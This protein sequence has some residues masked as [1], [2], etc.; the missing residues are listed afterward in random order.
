LAAPSSERWAAIVPLLDAAL[1]LEP[2]ERPAFLTERC[3]HEPGLR[4]EVERLLAAVDSLGTFLEDSASV[5]ASPLV[6]RI[7]RQERFGPGDRLGAYRIEREIGR[8]GMA[9]VYLAR[10]TRHDRPVAL[11]VLDRE[12]SSTLG[13]DRFGR[14]TA[15]AARLNHPHILPLFDSGLLDPGPGEPVLYY[16]MPYVD[17]RSLRERLREEPRLPIGVAV[18][19]A[20]QVAEAL[21]H[22]HERGIVH[23]DI[24]PENV[25]LAGDHAF[26][27]DFGIALAIDAAGTERLTRTGL[28]LGTPAYMSPE[29][30]T[31]GRLDGR[32]DLYSLGCM[33]YEML[34]GRPPFTGATAQA[35]LAQH[36]AGAAPPV[37]TFRTAVPAALER[38]VTRA[39]A[40]APEDRFPTGRALAEALAAA[41]GAAPTRMDAAY[42]F[43]MPALRSI[44]RHRVRAALVAGG[45]A[46][47]VAGFGLAAHS[48]RVTPTLDRRVVAIAPFRVS[49]ADSALRA[50]GEGMVEL[51]GSR[52]GGT[53]AVR[54]VEPH[55]L[56]RARRDMSGSAGDLT[57][58]QALGLAGRLGAGQL[59][60]GEILGDGARFTITA[61]LIDVASRRTLAQESVEGTGDSLPPVLD[62]LAA[63]LL[64]I[65]AGQDSRRLASLAR[66]PLPAL[67]A[68]LNAE[69]L[70]RRG[71][72]DSAT[73]SYEAAFRLDS[74][75]AIAALRLVQSNNW[76]DQPR[77]AAIAW[78]YR[79]S[80][81]VQDR[82]DVTA[83]L[84]PRYPGRSHYREGLEEAE[85]YAQVDPEE[86]RAWIE[87]GRGLF[88]DGPLL[89]LPE[90][91][92]RAAAAFARA[93]ALDSGNVPALRAL[94]VA[95]AT[96]GDTAGARR[97]LARLRRQQR[98]ST[99]Q[100]DFEPAWLLASVTADT[101]AL[102]RLLRRDSIAPA[103][104]TARP[105]AHGWAMLRFGLNLGLD[106]RDAGAVLDRAAAAA[107]TL[108]QRADLRWNQ[109]ILDGV[110]GR[111]DRSAAGAFNW[112]PSGLSVLPRQSDVARPILNFLF[113]DLDS[114]G[115]DSAGAVLLRQLGSR[116]TE[117]CCI[118]RFGAGEYALA[119]DRLDLAERAAE[120]LR[121][122]HGPSPDGEADTTL[123][124][125]TSHGYAIILEAQI[126]AR[127]GDGTA[128]ERLRRLDS[129]L[130]N[131]LED[132]VPL[133]GNLVAARLHEDR[134]ELASALAA[135]RRRWWGRWVDPGYVVYHR[136]EGRLAAL[137]GDTA[138]AIRAYRRYLTL[139]GDAEPRLQP[140][141]RQV[142]GAL[143]A[144][145]RATAGH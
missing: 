66:V 104:R 38:V 93:E 6:A 126:A 75:F 116:R 95:A 74:T 138:A 2:P 134:G 68:Y 100:I 61:G 91:H 120:D 50:L 28:S 17:G 92:A 122:Y 108:G 21:H 83:T 112:G 64:A 72:V 125:E 76:S 69:A 88:E 53:E 15:I 119:T 16:A 42:A 118:Q 111:S 24:K 58:S 71:M 35:V 113:T 84:G 109:A 73:M 105:A 140:R 133:V 45:L 67:R 123:G 136:E 3:E 62:R 26:V 44:G 56:L 135:V 37:R 77:A 129:M 34:A 18:V 36:A 11:K 30:A 4:R 127:R 5:V 7:V 99:S 63:R 89:D 132:M 102:R 40:K 57:E 86:P 79:D 22:A 142:R 96:L 25:L 128:A 145:E 9:M 33:V 97:A 59:I 12:L 60:E 137:A 20:S 107:A 41:A 43:A 103:W 14:E 81:S 144:L 46:V 124:T 19:I 131:P 98:D 32:S 80:L 29:Q 101:G 39:L 115:W 13:A 141:V 139:R 47:L 90:A 85:H 10:D 78:R 130:T 48:A 23:R 54:P 106:V 114:T 70:D 65:G 49:G 27:A 51:L 8:G 55:E 1:D 117:Q 143:A 82:A 110:R 87:L 31:T 52:L 121:R 94:S